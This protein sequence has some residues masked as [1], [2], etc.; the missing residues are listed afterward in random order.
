[1]HFFT[2]CNYVAVFWNDLQN[3]FSALY[4]ERAPIVF[5]SEM[6]IFGY[7]GNSDYAKALNYVLLL[8][9]YLIHAKRMKNDFTLDMRTFLF[10]LKYKLRIE[11]N[12]AMRNKSSYFEKFQRIFISLTS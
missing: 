2:E 7:E 6:L 3:W 1:M 5:S 12:I 9:K 8:S 11:K 10:F 4:N